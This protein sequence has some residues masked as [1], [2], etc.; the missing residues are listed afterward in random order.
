MFQWMQR[1]V[2]PSNVLYIWKTARCV[3]SYHVLRL[4]QSVFVKRRCWCSSDSS[5]WTSVRGSFS[6]FPPTTVK[7]RSTSNSVPLPIC[8]LSDFP[9]WKHS[10]LLSSSVEFVKYPCHQIF[11]CIAVFSL[12]ST[13]GT[14]WHH[15]PLPWDPIWC[16]TPF[17]SQSSR[18]NQSYNLL[19]DT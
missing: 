10:S 12:K 9:S 13:Q 5:L 8:L 6:H 3:L 2:S 4:G 19:T 7:W 16:E 17:N 18:P 15:L 1:D 11:K 14:K